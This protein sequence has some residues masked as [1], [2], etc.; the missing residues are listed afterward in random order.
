MYICIMEERIIL[1]PECGKR[2]KRKILGK[3]LEAHGV[4]KLWCNSC[5]EEKIISIS[6]DVITFKK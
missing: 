2:G 4:I 1:C 5:K 3:V 6:K